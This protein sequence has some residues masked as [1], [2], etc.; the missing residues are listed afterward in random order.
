MAKLVKK[1]LTVVPSPDT[2]VVA[3]RIYAIVGA[4]ADYNSPFVEIAAPDLDIVVPD[5]AP[6]LF[7]QDAVYQMGVS[8]VDD[9]GHESDI[10][11]FVFAYDPIAP[12]APGG[13]T[14]TTVS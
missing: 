2:D 8:A 10:S 9:Y 13:V 4:P 5:D 14:V 1:L 6:G 3:Y 7:Q 11:P 12:T